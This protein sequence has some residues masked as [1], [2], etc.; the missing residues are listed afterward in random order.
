[1]LDTKSGRNLNAGISLPELAI[2]GL[3]VTS[4]GDRA[5][6][7][8][9]AD[10]VRLFDTGSGKTVGSVP[11]KG[12]SIST[13]FVP[14]TSWGGR[15]VFS[16]NGSILTRAGS[17]GSLRIWDAMS[18]R[19]L[20]RSLAV[21]TRTVFQAVG[22][23]GALVI[24][25]DGTERVT[26]WDI[27]DGSL[28]RLTLR[29]A[30][31]SNS[32]V[33]NISVNGSHYGYLRGKNHIVIS[34][35]DGAETDEI[36]LAGKGAVTALGIGRDGRVIA[37]A[38]GGDVTIYDRKT[39]E[40]A[41]RQFLGPKELDMG[42][43]IRR[44]VLSPGGRYLAAVM[45]LDNFRTAIVVSDVNTGAGV[46]SRPRPEDTFIVTAATGL[47][48]RKDGGVLAIGKV[49]QEV[50]LVSMPDG[51]TVWT[52]GIDAD[53]ASSFAFSDDGN[54]LAAGD[55]TGNVTVWDLRTGARKAEFTGVRSFVTGLSFSTDAR[56]LAAGN[57]VGDLTVWEMESG[58]SL[59]PPF[60]A[61]SS[62]VSRIVA[63]PNAF[64]VKAADGSIT[65][66]VPDPATLQSELCQAAG[67]NLTKEEWSQFIPDEPYRQ[68][69]KE[70][71]PGGH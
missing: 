69:C 6:I 30:P 65:R 54:L 20:T 41:V 70:W 35:L 4:S 55:T 45:A 21:S 24:T 29:S 31:G 66:W 61:I 50:E 22:P 67:R 34:A 47:E 8:F 57:A 15:L 23:K 59:T 39:G 19:A 13:L 17:E 44:L 26:M 1:V 38:Q 42:F 43:T 53:F 63:I 18:G 71:P 40:K 46:Y 49:G 5:A 33:S 9:G 36:E 64:L 3:A 37:V 27:G 60:Q 25:A 48:F 56:Y 7:D 11:L 58:R 12:S 28:S 68:T 2:H 51:K 14:S 16:D 52:V 10:G 62:G 32:D